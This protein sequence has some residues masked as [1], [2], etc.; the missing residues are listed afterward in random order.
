MAFTNNL[1]LTK[2]YVC[3]HNRSFLFYIFQDII[4]KNIKTMFKTNY[5]F[6]IQYLQDLCP[7]FNYALNTILTLFFTLQC[8]LHLYQWK[9]KKKV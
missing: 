8:G 5:K 1:V 4:L 3:M 6:Y 7:S 2:L 9:T